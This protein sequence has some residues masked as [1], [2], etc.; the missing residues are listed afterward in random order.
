MKKA[1]IFGASGL[2]GSYL[3][4]ELLNSPDYERVT[5]VV[6]R[7]LEIRHP[8][9][10]MLIGDYD[11][12]PTIK[13]NIV[14]D[15]IFLTIGTT[16][17]LTPDKKKYYQVDHDY[18]VLAANIAKAKGARSAFLVSAVG[19]NAGSSI[20]YV[21]M[22]GETERDI[23]ALDLLH[24]HIFRPSMIRGN[25]KERRPL[26]KLFIGIWSF[27]NPLFIGGLGKY[28]GIKA[29]DIAAAMV[30]AAKVQ[31]DKIKIYEWKEMNELLQ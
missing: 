2:V 5:I 12:M 31:N 10:V 28:K 22:K 13:N 4:K 6:R 21:R 7:A 30:R 27:L 15:E 9:L 25:R 23:L 19:A 20:F 14:A 11:S 3:L 24:T 18:P 16:R 17:K 1:V 29:E 26:E 8:K